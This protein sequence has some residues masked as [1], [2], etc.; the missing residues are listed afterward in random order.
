MKKE[1]F[2]KIVDKI[3]NDNYKVSFEKKGEAYITNLEGSCL[4]VLMGYLL[5][6]KQM[7]KKYNIDSDDMELA[8]G[9]VDIIE[10]KLIN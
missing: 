7:Y 6:G 5:L 8:K 1:E 4:T 2:D 10:D 3:L 9:L